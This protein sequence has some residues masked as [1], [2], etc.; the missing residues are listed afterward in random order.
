MAAAL[1]DDARR[2]RQLHAADGD[3]ARR[4]RVGRQ[5]GRGGEGLRRG[6]RDA[7]AARRREVRRCSPACRGVADLQVEVFSGA[8]AA[9]DRR[10][11]G[12]RIARYGLERGGRP[13]GGRGRRRRHRCHRAARR[14]A[15]HSRSSCSLPEA[16]RAARGRRSAALPLTAPGGEKVPLGARGRRSRETQTPEAISHEGASAGWSCSATCA[17]ATSAASSPRR[18]SAWP[19]C[20]DA[21]RLLPALGRPVR[22]P[23]ARDGP[24]GAGRPAVARDHLLCCCSSRSATCGRRRW[25]S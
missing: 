20:S 25:S 21:G 4:G 22:E 3:A 1:G 17:A 10:S 19:R 5:G 16:V 13:A 14:P 7:R 12:R 15:A 9:A 2:R 11:T 23:G 6:Q 18:S 8:V 24:A